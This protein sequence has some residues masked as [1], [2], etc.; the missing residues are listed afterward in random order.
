MNSKEIRSELFNGVILALENMVDGGGYELQNKTD[1]F[2]LAYEY[3]PDSFAHNYIRNKFYHNRDVYV[4]G[5]GKNANY[6][7]VKKTK[8]GSITFYKKA[9]EEVFGKDKALATDIMQRLLDKLYDNVVVN[10]MS[11]TT[12][13][14]LSRGRGA[15]AHRVSREVY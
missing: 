8:G 7:V 1:K 11:S 4:I 6:I 14:D 15:N 9:F 13:V 5:R 10:S 2:F 12:I 3:P